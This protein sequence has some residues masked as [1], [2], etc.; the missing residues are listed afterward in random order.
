MKEFLFM[1][2]GL[3][4]IFAILLVCALLDLNEEEHRFGCQVEDDHD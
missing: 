4:A 3:A 2:S 1:A